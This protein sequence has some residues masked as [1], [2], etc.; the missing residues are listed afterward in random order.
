MNRHIFQKGSLVTALGLA[1]GLSGVS[2]VQAL[3][4][5]EIEIHGFFTAGAT[6]SD[7]DKRYLRTTDDDIS[8]DED[9]AFALQVFI[10]VDDKI[11]L[12]A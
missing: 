6:I 1:L 7:V 10:P 11:S 12:Q 8:F 2:G 5:D 3:S 4:A 9:S